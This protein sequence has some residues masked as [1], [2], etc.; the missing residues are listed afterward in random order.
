MPET[1]H[2]PVAS[3]QVLPLAAG[4]SIDPH[5]HDGHQ[6]VYAGSGVLAVTTPAG[7]WFA[8]GNRAI[9][10]PA[11]TVHAHR[12]YG[13]LDLHTVG[14]PP[15]AA[16]LGLETPTVLVV[17]PLLRE[18]IRAYTRAPGDDG[19]ERG[20][21]RAV[22]LDELRASPQRPVHLPEPADPR[23]VAVCAQLRRNPAD[24][25]TL[26]ALGAAAGVS[27]RT[28]TRL[29]RAELGMTFPQW[30]TQVRLYHA[31]R[32]L[33]DGEPVTTVGRRC[34]WSS[35]SAF[36]DAFRRA[37]GHTPGVHAR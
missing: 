35:T 34:G 24:H 37:F 1:R 7:T 6:I 23:L 12:A 14:L 5:W 25:R 29:F 36:I 21:L 22:L 17:G 33:A 9:W 16:P 27:E 28:L 11:G 32:M 19:P 4:E 30:R 18:L 10:I 3:T 2:A 13:R 31:L 15:D 26:A 20:R 8:P